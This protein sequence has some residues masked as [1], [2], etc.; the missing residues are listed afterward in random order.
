MR[1]TTKKAPVQEFLKPR[2]SCSFGKKQHSFLCKSRNHLEIFILVYSICCWLKFAIL[3]WPCLFFCCIQHHGESEV[4][5]W[6]MDRPRLWRDSAWHFA[7]LCFAEREPWGKQ[8]LHLEKNSRNK[9]TPG[10]VYA[11]SGK[12]FIFPLWYFF[13][14]RLYMRELGQWHHGEGF[15]LQRMLEHTGMQDALGKCLGPCPGNF[16]I[17][18]VL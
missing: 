12:Q 15:G 2:S 18:A 5:H 14:L 10:F 17:R 3:H 7:N 1:N 6:A 16:G 13:R 8:G 9:T 11:F 4:L